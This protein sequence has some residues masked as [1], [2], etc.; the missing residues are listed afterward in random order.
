MSVA[1]LL[2]DGMTRHEILLFMDGHSKYNQIY[3]AEEDIH[4]TAFRC[5]GT[6]STYAWKIMPYR[7][8]NARATYQRAMNIIFHDMIVYFMKIYIDDI[9]VKFKEKSEHMK[10][11][12]KVIWE[13]A[14]IRIA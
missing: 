9:V 8:K 4:K 11:L 2:I 1:Y 7:L 3:V 5:Y 6:L 12:R 14:S 10:K 13:I